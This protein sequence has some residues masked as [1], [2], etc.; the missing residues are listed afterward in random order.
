MERRSAG[1]SHSSDENA[2]PIS[3]ADNLLDADVFD[4]GGG[5]NDDDDD[6]GS[7]GAGNGAV[8]MMKGAVLEEGFNE[9]L[10]ISLGNFFYIRFFAS[11]PSSKKNGRAQEKR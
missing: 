9:G 1:R 2:P 8:E 7:S 10:E 6:S 3:A 5:D 4:A 11:S